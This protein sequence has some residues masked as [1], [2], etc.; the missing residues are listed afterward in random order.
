VTEELALELEQTALYRIWGDTDLLLY[1]GIS[2]DFGRRWKQHAKA[3][4]WWG[5]MRRLT[6]DEW[7]DRREDAE[8][9]EALAVKAE[10]PKYNKKLIS[11]PEGVKAAR[12]ALRPAWSDM[13]VAYEAGEPVE[14]MPGHWKRLKVA[15]VPW[16]SVSN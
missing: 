3:Q 11:R 4:P 10:R 5:E 13:L 1:I 16:T 6:V 14:I 8:T 7:F 9:A 15:G 12:T 2:D